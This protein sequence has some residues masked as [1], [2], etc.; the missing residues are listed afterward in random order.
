MKAP[1]K[2]WSVKNGAFVGY[3]MVLRE[4]PSTSVPGKMLP[5]KEED[6]MP[7]AVDLRQ[8]HVMKQYSF[9]NTGLTS[10][11]HH[12]E[13]IACVNASFAELIDDW[14]SYRHIYDTPEFY[15][16]GHPSNL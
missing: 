10:L 9:E 14:I 15:D 8:V 5:A 6:W 12:G 2:D 3:T 7:Y 4:I 13:F 11:Y 16:P 1:P